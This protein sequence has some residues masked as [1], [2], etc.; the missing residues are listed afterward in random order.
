MRRFI[1]H[2]AVQ[3]F[4]SHNNPG[5]LFWRRLDKV[6]VENRSAIFNLYGA[7]GTGKSELLEEFIAEFDRH[8]AE[9]PNIIRLYHNF[10]DGSDLRTILDDWKDELAQFGCTFPNF[11]KS[12]ELDN[13]AESFARDIRNWTGD[14][15]RLIIFIDSL[16]LLTN[17]HWLKD[18]LIFELPSTLWV[19][20]GRNK[21]NWRNVAVSHHLVKSVSRDDA[22]YFLSRAGVQNSELRECI[23]ELTRG[24]P[25]FLDLCI[26][27]CKKF[28]FES[29]FGVLI[30]EM[31]NAFDRHFEQRL[32]SMNDRDSA[33]K[34]LKMWAELTARLSSNADELE[35]RYNT[36]FDYSV[37]QLIG[38]GQFEAAEAIVAVFLNSRAAQD[39]LSVHAFFDKEMGIIKN[40]QGK[41]DEELE[42]NQSAFTKYSAKL[43]EEDPESILAMERLIVNLLE[44]GQFDAAFQFRTRLL[45]LREHLMQLDSNTTLPAMQN[46]ASAL[47]QLGCYDEASE[48]YRLLLSKIVKAVGE[49][50]PAAIDILEKIANVLDEKR[51]LKES[52]ELI[53]LSKENEPPDDA[54]DLEMR[55]EVL[56]LRQSVLT[57]R[58]KVLGEKNAATLETMERVAET[59]KDLQRLD[60][61]IELQNRAFELRRDIHGEDHVET[62][63]SMKEL[64][65]MLRSNRQ[66]KDALELARH[67]LT[68]N[69]NVFGRIHPN[70]LT[71]MKNIADILSDMNRYEEAAELQKRIVEIRQKTLGDTHIDTAISMMELAETNVMLGHHDEA[72]EL[73]A[74]ATRN[75]LLK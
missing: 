69:E 7:G 15:R 37:Q 5:E 11:A 43:G 45:N 36:F 21:L 34:Y 31:H 56:R 66:Y 8:R 58:L 29:D 33:T 70:T 62:L 44:L 54:I 73:L 17:A 72:E 51:L 12:K 60:E 53:R 19:L 48:T 64:S 23:Y 50:H 68:I 55:N 59:L 16:E 65:A 22:Y 1:K 32:D 28:R 13:M 14:S 75:E 27:I 52:Q 61:A 57:R 42:Y 49:Q 67:C 4:K 3:I 41:F 24:Y 18:E 38:Y 71:A 39:E 30:A 10:I 20:A 63:R 35:G 47:R 26:D 40:T 46:L 2:S 9:F 25:P 6:I 74:A